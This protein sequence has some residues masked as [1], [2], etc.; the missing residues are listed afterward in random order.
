VGNSKHFLA[1][2]AKIQISPAKKSLELAEMEG[3]DLRAAVRADRVDIIFFF[4]TNHDYFSIV[5]RRLFFLLIIYAFYSK[6]MEKWILF[7]GKM[8]LRKCSPG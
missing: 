4:E 8:P 1:V 3:G 6:A 5:I 7:P 2:L